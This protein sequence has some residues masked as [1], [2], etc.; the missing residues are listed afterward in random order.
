MNKEPLDL[1][2]VRANPIPFW[3]ALH[4]T[5]TDDLKN[6]RYIKAIYKKSISEINDLIE[7]KKWICDDCGKEVPLKLPE[8]Y[9]KLRNF[10][11]WT[12]NRNCCTICKDCEEKIITQGRVLGTNEGWYPD[13]EKLLK[14]VREEHEREIMESKK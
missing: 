10:A 14:K 2:Y 12:I 13:K 11:L 9:E 6:G 7:N 1:H 4:N 8:T 3:Q 5:L